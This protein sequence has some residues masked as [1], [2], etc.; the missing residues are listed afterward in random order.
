VP[1]VNR[2]L[3]ELNHID[4]NAVRS[5]RAANAITPEFITLEK[6]INATTARYQAVIKVWQRSIAQRWEGVGAAPGDAVSIVLHLTDTSRT[7]VVAS[8][9]ED[10][11]PEGS[12]GPDIVANWWVAL[13]PAP[14]N[15]THWAYVFNG[16]ELSPT[17][18]GVPINA[19]AG[20]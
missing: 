16:I 1:Y 3:A 6:S 14:T 7:C 2:V 4:G 8:V 17:P 20:V 9:H 18:G 13:L 15:A 19:C 12:G 11:G 10:L 5:A